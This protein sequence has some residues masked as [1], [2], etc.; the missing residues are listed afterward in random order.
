MNVSFLCCDLKLLFGDD[1]N[2][3]EGEDDGGGLD[4][5]GGDG[6]VGGGSSISE[7]KKRSVAK[8]RNRSKFSL[9]KYLGNIP[10]PLK[11]IAIT[12][13]TTIGITIIGAHLLPRDRVTFFSP[14]I[15]V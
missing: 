9:R 3:D 10:V 7:E 15:P 14:E 6:G 1:G 2:S 12:K 4:E 11:K 8:F 13:I 5:G